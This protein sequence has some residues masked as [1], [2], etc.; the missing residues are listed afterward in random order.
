MCIVS[1]ADSR[2]CSSACGIHL[3]TKHPFH[4]KGNSV[5]DE[6]RHPLKPPRVLSPHKARGG[7]QRPLETLVAHPKVLPIALPLD[8]AL[9]FAQ[10]HR[11]GQEIA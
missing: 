8:R 6:H 1:E 5:V 7:V 10:V 3:H 2:Q 4:T 9:T 11:D